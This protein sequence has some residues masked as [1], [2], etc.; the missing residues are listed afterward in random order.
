MNRAGLFSLDGKKIL[1][2]GA[3]GKLGRTLCEYLV[4]DGATVF[5]VDVDTSALNDLKQRLSPSS[6][7]VVVLPADLA[8]EASRIEMASS[9]GVH[10]KHL[11]GVVFA[12]AFVGTSAADGW[13]VDFAEQTLPPW[14][15]ALELNLTAPFHLTQ[16]LEVLLRKGN[17]PS[18][19]NVGSIYGS[20]AP[21]WS[22]Y[23][24]V[25]M[26]NPAAYAASKGGL[27]QLN[28]WLAS[29]LSPAIR[30]N[31]V[32]PGGIF[33]EQPQVF[34]DRYEKKVALGRMA[35]EQ[36]IVGPIVALLGSSS[37]YVT[38]Q[39]LLVDGGFEMGAL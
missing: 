31:M 23:E 1:V 3:A 20:K 5:A 22:L 17:N 27:V 33:R 26:A 9:L 34:V 25:A 14:R 35:T 38:G 8:D 10:T 30:V 37:G 28:R 32:S 7:S 12:A 21:D 24:G 2:T 11:D 36:D 15:A 6:N 19:V 13:A 18:I 16:L 39:N 29:A 4:S